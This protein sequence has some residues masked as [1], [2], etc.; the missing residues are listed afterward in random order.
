MDG[1][2]KF[3][4]LSLYSMIVADGVVK[5]KELETLYRIGLETYKLTP[6]E[7]NKYVVSAGSSIVVPD[8]MEDRVSILYEMAEIAWADGVI[9]KTEKDLL[10]RYAIRLGFKDENAG[11][12]A[13][14]LLQQVKE[15][16]SKEEVINS[17]IND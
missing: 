6:E 15:G 8:K 7:I 9:D 1:I 10:S 14:F 4:F 2:Q 3:R 16:I 5:A 12:I 17:I 11:D 13:E